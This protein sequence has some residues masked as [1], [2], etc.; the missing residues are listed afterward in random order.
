M[1]DIVLVHFKKKFEATLD[2]TFSEDIVVKIKKDFF[3]TWDKYANTK[4]DLNKNETLLNAKPEHL[5]SQRFKNYPF[6]I[7]SIRLSNTNIIDLKYD[8]CIKFDSAK[9]LFELITK[10]YEFVCSN[11]IDITIKNLT[12]NIEA[13]YNLETLSEE[14]LIP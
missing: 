6:E 8:S 11:T 12:D 13:N 14:G 2:E 3:E 4:Y 9:F 10:N 1:K 5:N 7:M